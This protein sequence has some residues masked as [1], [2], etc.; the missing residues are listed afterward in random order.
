MNSY[1]KNLG[2]YRI[3]KKRQFL[4]PPPSMNE[5]IGF[6]SPLNLHRMALEK[7]IVSYIQILPFFYAFHKVLYCIKIKIDSVIE[8]WNKISIIYTN[9]KK[10]VCSWVRCSLG[11]NYLLIYINRLF[12]N[13]LINKNIKT[14]CYIPIK[15]RFAPTASSSQ[16]PQK[17]CRISQTIVFSSLL[18]PKQKI[19]FRLL[20]P[21]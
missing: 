2:Y 21:S 11:L 10:Y 18:H 14:D 15:Q 8:M 16:S 5:S 20:S 9:K 6:F 1:N 19:Y 7:E 3:D 13:I 4:V 17:Q 12:I